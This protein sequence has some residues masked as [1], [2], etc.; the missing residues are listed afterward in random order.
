MITL[1]AKTCS[2]IDDVSQATN[3]SSTVNFLMIF[4]FSELILS[5]ANSLVSHKSDFK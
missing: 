2:K 5:G 1:K 4:Y 3:I